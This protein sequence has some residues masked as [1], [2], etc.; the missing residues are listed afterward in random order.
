[1]D[2]IVRKYSN[3]EITIEWRPSLCHHTLTCFAGLK[4]VFDPRERP[5]VKIKEADTEKI[6]DQI[7]KCPSKALSFYYNNKAINN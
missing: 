2:K 1:M 7:N 6:I 3:D 4:S 5:W